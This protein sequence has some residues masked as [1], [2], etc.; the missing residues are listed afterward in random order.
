MKYG[1]LSIIVLAVA[2]LA[3]C[4]QTRSE[5]KTFL[6]DKSLATDCPAA[7]FGMTPPA[8]C[9]QV[10]ISPSSTWEG[11]SNKIAGFQYEAGNVYELKVR[12]TYDTSGIMDTPPSYQL[13]KIV[14]KVKSS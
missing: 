9:L 11:F 5:V 8:T 10:K 3:G 12:V 2:L 6:V 13:I 1:L 4:N 14:S 7:A